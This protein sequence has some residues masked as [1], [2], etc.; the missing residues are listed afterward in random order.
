[1]TK[2]D[3]R[4]QAELND[5]LHA[6]A[7]HNSEGFQSD[8][9]K[10]LAKL[11]PKVP[12]AVR[13]IW[14]RTDGEYPSNTEMHATLQTAIDALTKATTAL[15]AES[16]RTCRMTPQKRSQYKKVLSEA[17]HE[18][19]DQLDELSSKYPLPS[20]VKGY[21]L[22]IGSDP[23]EQLPCILLDTPER[24]ILWMKRLPH[25]SESI[26]SLGITE[27]RQLLYSHDLTPFR[28][29]HCDF[30]HVYLPDKP[31][32]ILDVDNYLYK[33]IIDILS[34][35]LFAK[36]SYDNFSY[37]MYNLPSKS[38]RSGTYIHIC[39]RDEKVPF[40]QD[41]EKMILAV[42]SSQNP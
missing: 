32:G 37:A 19:E 31:M 23:C 34:M 18:L 20:G 7:V 41:F 10:E 14:D 29:W 6:F 38:I 2:T 5:L 35:A 30:I 16:D 39:T 36:D 22:D 25:K 21:L 24:I 13:P 1:M 26:G 42:Q 27:L 4:T 33:P 12:E 11:Y 15:Q 3:D 28:S 40:F 8:Y 9:Q 17:I